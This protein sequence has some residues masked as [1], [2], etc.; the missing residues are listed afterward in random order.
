[1]D[2][3]ARRLSGENGES[4]EVTGIEGTVERRDGAAFT[5]QTASGPVAARRAASCLLEPNDGDTVLLARTDRGAYWIFT[6]LERDASRSAEISVDGDLRLRTARG[7]IALVAQEGVEII[8]AATTKIVSSGIDVRSTKMNVVVEGLELVGTYVKAEVGRAKLFAESLDHVLDRFS[9]KVKRSY[10][11]VEDL[12][13]VQAGSM[14]HRVEKTLRVHAHD[15]A[16]TADGLV[17]IDGKQIH[18]G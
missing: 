16:L 15:T 12:D 4:G 17:K 1:M 5:V 10:R 14:H 9:Q 6:V 11:H 13:Q 8:S 2:N 3:L 7:K 18:V